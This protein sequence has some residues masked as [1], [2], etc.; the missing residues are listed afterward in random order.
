MGEPGSV[1]GGNKL[2]KLRIER[3]E[4]MGF[5]LSITQRTERAPTSAEDYTPSFE[6]R[7][8]ELQE[9]YLADRSL[10]E[11]L[12]GIAW[13]KKNYPDHV[14]EVSVMG[15]SGSGWKTLVCAVED[16][17]AVFLAQFLMHNSCR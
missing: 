8:G 5:E 12:A 17:G 9:Y 4:A 10:S 6:D 15:F 11:N 16:H 13:L 7:I 1:L 3:L 14:V 2:S